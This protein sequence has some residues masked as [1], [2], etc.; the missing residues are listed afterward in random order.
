MLASSRSKNICGVNKPLLPKYSTIS[1]GF[2]CAIMLC[3]ILILKHNPTTT[4][5]QVGCLS[6][7]LAGCP[8]HPP[9]LELSFCM[10]AYLLVCRRLLYTCPNAPWSVDL[11]FLAV[12]KQRMACRTSMQSN[13]FSSPHHIWLGFRPGLFYLLLSW[14]SKSKSYQSKVR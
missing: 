8:G 7:Q 10:H 3:L 1:L 4:T 13:F 5:T 14:A 11:L 6:S 2:I 12:C 9:A